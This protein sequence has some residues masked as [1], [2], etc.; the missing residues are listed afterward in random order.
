M[1]DTDKYEGCI[2]DMKGYDLAILAEELL[3]EVKRLRELKIAEEEELERLCNRAVFYEGE[4]NLAQRAK[5]ELLAEVKR[6]Q[7]RLSMW[8]DWFKQ[9][10]ANKMQDGDAYDII[11]HN[12][13]TCLSECS[14]HCDG[15]CWICQTKELIE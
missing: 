5:Q 7:E 14:N 11:F 15:K 4:Y 9:G 10:A 2:A 12:Q 3:A 13:D 8:E 1:I 6:L